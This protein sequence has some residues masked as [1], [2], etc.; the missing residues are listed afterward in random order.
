MHLAALRVLA[1]GLGIPTE[2]FPDSHQRNESEMRLANYPEVAA[3][4]LGY[5]HSTGRISEHVDSGSATLL[6]QDD[7]GGLEIEDVTSREFIPVTCPRP[8]LL[9]YLGDTMEH[10]SNRILTSAYHRVSQPP[11][12]HKSGQVLE[13]FSVMYFKKHQI[14]MPA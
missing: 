5:A 14:E 7:V 1:E 13:R 11:V 6:W 4:N 8:A 2:Y 3:S 9:V 10:W 12:Q